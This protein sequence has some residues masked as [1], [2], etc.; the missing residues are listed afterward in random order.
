MDRRLGVV[1]VGFAA[2]ASGCVHKEFDDATPETSAYTLEVTGDAAGEG[3]TTSSL[4]DE[5]LA[6]TS[7]ALTGGQLPEYL[8]D[9]RVSVKALNEGVRAVLD[10]I[11]ELILTRPLAAGTKQ[12]WGPISRGGA[13]YRFTMAKVALKQFGWLLE[14]KAVDAADSSYAPVMAGGIVVGDVARRGR[15]AMGIDLDKLSSIDPGIKGRGKLLVGFAHLLGF[16]VL[17]YALKGFTPDAAEFDPVDALFGGWRGPN[18]GTDVK[19]AVYANLTDTATSAKELAVLHA[20]WLPGLGGRVDAAAT[21]GDIPDGKALV[22]FACFNKDCSA[23]GGYLSVSLCDKT[24]PGACS[25]VKEE[26]TPSACVKGLETAD[27]PNA[28]PSMDLTMS[29]APENPAV[30]TAMPDGSGS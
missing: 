27:T 24:I 26:G 9:T 28:D 1:I 4:E 29:G 11:A 3:L 10:P 16:K 15:G 6:S 7:L 30:P 25:P 17:K 8:T 18:G 22:A 5:G 13:T 19:V 23:N 2:A 12:V 21:F 20:R 14:A